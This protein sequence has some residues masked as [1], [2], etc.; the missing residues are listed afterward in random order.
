M[1]PARDE[2]PMAIRDCRSAGIQVIMV[3]GDHPKTGA[4]I[5][6]NIGIVVTRKTARAAPRSPAVHIKH[7]RIRTLC[8]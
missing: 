6:Q 2:V 7:C 3:T 5:A 4:A 8:I 1:D